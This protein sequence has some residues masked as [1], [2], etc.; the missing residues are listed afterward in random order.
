MVHVHLRLLERFVQ[1][2]EHVYI[3]TK[4]RKRKKAVKPTN[5]GDGAQNAD[6]PATAAETDNNDANA[7]DNDGHSSGEENSRQ[8][9]QDRA[10]D[11]DRFESKYMNPTCINT[12]IAFLK[13]YQELNTDQ[14]MRIIKFLHR[15]TE[16]KKMDI[17][18]TRID[19]VNLL[20]NMMQ[21][22]ERLPKSHGAYKAMDE[23]VRHFFRKMFKK[24][25]KTPALY[26]EVP[27]LQLY[28][29]SRHINPP[30]SSS[31][32]PNSPARCTTSKTANPPP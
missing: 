28:Y 10:F 13:M 26:V 27:L 12:Y 5:P 2:H 31:S 9:T 30:T 32:S 15:V 22:P 3:R 18:L 16:K 17:L 29:S 19:I 11:F 24:L 6:T 1:Q 25:Q 20:Y 8:I 23:F 21:G 4:R 7:D 14:L